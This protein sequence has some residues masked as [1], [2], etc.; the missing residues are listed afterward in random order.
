MIIDYLFFT[1]KYSCSVLN[2]LFF[3]VIVFAKSPL[4]IS[5]YDLIL[6]FCSQKYG[7]IKTLNI[8]LPKYFRNSVRLLFTI[9]QQ[10]CVPLECKFHNSMR[11]CLNTYLNSMSFHCLILYISKY[12]RVEH[13]R[14]LQVEQFLEVKSRQLF[15]SKMLVSIFRT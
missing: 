12:F 7:T 5:F 11:S 4:M 2:Y 9:V 8:Y 14:V 1:I 15:F 13:K 6:I 3:F 10:L